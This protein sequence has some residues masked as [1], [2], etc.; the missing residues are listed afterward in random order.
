MSTG[1]AIEVAVRQTMTAL[2]IDDEN[3]YIESILIEL[4][5]LASAFGH[6]CDYRAGWDRE[7]AGMYIRPFGALGQMAFLAEL[8]VDSFPLPD[9]RFHHV[10][11]ELSPSEV[12]YG[13][14]ESWLTLIVNY[15]F[16]CLGKG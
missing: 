7:F 4:M 14:A 3:A 16:A 2:A 10:G 13:A 12:I 8:G 1:V 11:D 15:V 6:A 5:G 9:R